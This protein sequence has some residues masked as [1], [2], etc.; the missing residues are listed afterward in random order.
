MLHFVR[1]FAVS[2]TGLRQLRNRVSESC[3]VRKAQVWCF[4]LPRTFATDTNTC[5][6]LPAA[7]I[8]LAPLQPLSCEV[9]EKCNRRREIVRFR[10]NRVTG[11]VR[12]RQLG[13]VAVPP[14]DFA[15]SVGPPVWVETN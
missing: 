4:V 7:T 12:S 1:P 3:F 6:T 8:P 2:S 14:T 5:R 11:A 10:P 9:P 15:H 13:A